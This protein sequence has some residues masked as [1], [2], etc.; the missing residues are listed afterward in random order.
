VTG[1]SL[2]S[3]ADVVIV[4]RANVDLTVRIPH[5]PSPGRTV[6]STGLATTPGGK[7]LNQAVAVA[8]LGGRACLVANVGADSWG[9]ELRT[10]LA[11]AGVDTESF[12]LLP[13]ATTAAAIIEVTPDGEPY[14]VLA[15]SVATELNAEDV[16]RALARRPAPVVVGQLDLQPTAIDGIL[17]AQRP[18]LLIGNLVP[19]PDLRRNVL[20]ELDLFVVNIHEAAAVLGAGTIDPVAAARQLCRL[21]PRAAIVTAGPRGAAYSGPDGS[22]LV[23]A[24]SVTVVDASGA[25]D[26][27]LGALALSLSRGRSVPDS[28]AAAVR[29]GG[30]AVQHA[31]ALLP[32]CAP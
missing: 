1:T 22:D 25:G 14:V 19:H 2:D 12:R 4:G 29:V 32:D 17:R 7:S 13:E 5:R 30:E 18:D 23:P 11:A 16:T 9:H 21:G 6:F 27:F 3:R 24:T 8:R 31:G 15:L 28:V 26:A 10:A 20:A